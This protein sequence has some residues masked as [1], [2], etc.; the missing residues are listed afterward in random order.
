MGTAK[1]ASHEDADLIETLARTAG[2]SD[3][4]A[5]V[6][7]VG[8]FAPYVSMLARSFRLP[9][10]EYDDL[11]QVGRIALYR[12]VC[13]FDASRSHFTPFAK[14]CIRNAMTSFMRSYQAESK[15]V[16]DRL[17]LDELQENGLM[18]KSDGTDLPENSLLAE[19]FFRDIE[20]FFRESLS[21]SERQVMQCRLSGLGSAEIAVLTGKSVKSVENTLF[22]ARQ[23]L[24]DHLKSN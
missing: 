15:L 5:F 18:I 2:Q 17:S 16:S 12:A 21:D 8:I 22:R 7:L 4:F 24:R 19:E 9:E 13:S 14:V 11:C 23:K 10:S 20:H 3:R 1:G 6:E